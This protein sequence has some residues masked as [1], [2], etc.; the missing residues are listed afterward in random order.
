MAD[1]ELLKINPETIYFTLILL[2]AKGFFPCN[3]AAVMSHYS[4]DIFMRLFENTIETSKFNL[5]SVLCALSNMNLIVHLIRSVESFT[6]ILCLRQP[7][8]FYIHVKYL[9]I[10]FNSGSLGI[11]RKATNEKSLTHSNG[12]YL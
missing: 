2:M 10:H 6:L 7:G 4:L 8:L 5:S 3:G 11:F 12:I 1:Q 9:S